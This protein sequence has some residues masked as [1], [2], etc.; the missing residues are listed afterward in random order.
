MNIS[1]ACR[2]LAFHILDLDSSEDMALTWVKREMIDMLERP[3][4]RKVLENDWREESCD[5]IV[6][7]PWLQELVERYNQKL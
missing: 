1:E 3:D 2:T 5:K 7:N 6:E 4:N